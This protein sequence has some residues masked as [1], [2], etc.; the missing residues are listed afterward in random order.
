MKKLLS[1]KDMSFGKLKFDLK[2]RISLVLLLTSILSLQAKDSYSQTTKVTL[3]MENVRV[4][5]VIDAIESETEFKFFFNNEVVNLHRKVSLKINKAR[6]EKVLHKLFR[7]TDTS[8]EVA[9]RKILLK[10]RKADKMMEKKPGQQAF[11]VSGTV[12][13]PD[14]FPLLGATVLLQGTNQ[15]TVSDVNG[16]FN[17][18]DV[19]PGTYTLIVMYVGFTK[20]SQEIVVTDTDLTVDV[21][22]TEDV[23]SLDQVIVTGVTNP[24]S[25]LESSVSVT[26]IG[27]K[28]I[29]KTVPRNL[30]E[31][32]RSIPGIRAEAAA[33]D[34][35]ANISARGVPISAGGAKYVQLQE[36]GLPVMLFGD[37]SFANTDNYLRF[38]T[39]IGRIEAI[40]GGSASILSTNSPAGIINLISKTGTV[41]GGSARTTFGL[42]YETFRT[43]FEYGAP[44]G[45]DLNFHFGGFYRVGEGIRDADFTANN[46][47]QFKFNITKKFESG[48][49]RLYAKYLNDRAISYSIFPIKVTGTNN[50]PTWSNAP[51]FDATQDVLHSTFLSQNLG[52]GPDGERRRSKVSDGNF[53]NSAS[54]GLSAAFDLGNDWRIKNNGRFSVTNGRVLVPF[55]AQ[56]GTPQDIAA[57]FG[58]GATL[59]F[60]NDGALV[61]NN[62]LVNRIHL[63]DTELN[64]LNNFM[65]DIQLSRSFENLDVT[66]G[67]FKA[68][69][70]ISMSW[71]W[72]SYLQEVAPRNAR[73]INV[74]DNTG[75]PLS[76]N[77][78]YAYGVPFWGNCC[79]R[80]YDTQYNISAPYVNIS[81]NPTEKLA[82]DGGIR[83]DKGRVD[84]SFAGSNQT[85]FDINNDGALSFPEQSVSAIDNA[86]L[87]PVNYDYD[88]FSYSLGL[89]YKL[90]DK[91]AIFAR[92]SRGASA[93][94]DR[95]LFTGLDSYTD[96]DRVNALDFID[97]AELGFKGNL[98]KG[99]LYLT[100]FY[101]QTTEEGGFEATTGQIIE[102]DYEAYGVELETFFTFNHLNLNGG[103]TYTDAEI[104][105]GDNEGNTPRRQPDFNYSLTSSY[106]FGSSRRSSV[107]LSLIGQT[108]SFAQDSNE[109]VMPGFGVLNG[110]L[111]VGLTNRI[112]LNIA[113]NNL[114]DSIGITESEDGSIVEGVDNFIRARSIPGRSLT[115]SILYEF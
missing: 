99:A 8:F 12:K 96:S 24:K 101:A 1:S 27:L 67:F 89:N 111:N 36:D 46:G 35:N 94:P 43:D 73:L 48:F 83:Y 76:E 82:I 108:K 84:G 92:Y 81:F 102:N 16:N 71:L 5:E 10:P 9:N 103:I 106:D 18:P 63:F 26:T 105:S 51:N 34:G 95:I 61:A 57:S 109:L 90:H 79:T 37:I 22:L 47:G 30:N 33:G 93:K 65:N 7:N 66:V 23:Q 54:I 70:N 114:L 55:L 29:E 62:S 88:Y 14:G 40:R 3:D 110:F 41:E 97:Q 45:D 44:I 112:T 78:L 13:E 25:K 113:G 17:L 107:G 28:A 53:S 60:A 80:N 75:A 32:F 64:N 86:D 91:R 50:D 20:L 4:S 52:L 15:G 11:T 98:G 6:I 68:A 87:T 115:L 21:V 19:A 49:I 74:S 2:M 104:T 72:N 58:D 59:S 38:D 85:T 42:D 56:I 69:Q 100:A 39:N 31:I 77:G